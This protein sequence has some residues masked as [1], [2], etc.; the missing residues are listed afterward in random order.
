MMPNPAFTRL[1]AA[2]PSRLGILFIA[3]LIT[4][5]VN[6]ATSQTSWI[7]TS[8]GT[9]STAA[10]W[11]AGAPAT[12]PQLAI[13]PGTASLQHAI[14]LA[15]AT[16]R[17]SI[18]QQFDFVAGGIGYTISGTAG[19]VVGFF[20]RSGGAVN[21]FLNNDD[22]TQTF[23]VPIKLTSKTGN[24]GS[25]AAMTWKAA[26]GSIVFKGNNNAP[27]APWTVNLNG[28]SALTIDG[29]FNV[30]IGSSGPGQI[31]NTNSPL[32]PNTGIIK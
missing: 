20:P 16:G 31:V 6:T 11:S 14:N 9:W 22:S 27:A 12:G 18:G 8:D 32:N 28:A 24:P 30:T 3:C 29:S 21:G 7:S 13:Y 19:S 23:K 1:A 10:N 15:G 2:T 17:V 26:A 5:A 25:G 4:F